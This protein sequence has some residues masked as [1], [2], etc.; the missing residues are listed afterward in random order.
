MK[1]A[2]KQ[3][4]EVAQFKKQ[5]EGPTVSSKLPKGGYVAAGGEPNALRGPRSG[6]SVSNGAPKPRLIAALNGLTDDQKQDQARR[7]AQVSY[8][9]IYL[10]RNA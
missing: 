2:N 7:R 5:F 8:R 6:N 3:K 9:Q 1:A 4:A 10:V